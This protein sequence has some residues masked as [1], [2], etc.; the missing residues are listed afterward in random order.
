ML[1]VHEQTKLQVEIDFRAESL[2]E[3]AKKILK[4]E[5]DRGSP[6]YEAAQFIMSQRR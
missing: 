3:A 6:V 4:V 2:R 1:N 5:T